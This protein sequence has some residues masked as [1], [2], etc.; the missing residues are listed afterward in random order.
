MCINYANIMIGDRNVHKFVW[1]YLGG[2]FIIFFIFALTSRSCI[3][4]IFLY[5]FHLSTWHCLYCFK[6]IYFS[7]CE[8]INLFSD[9]FFYSSSIYSIHKTV[10]HTIVM[11]DSF[12]ETFFS[13]NS[14]KLIVWLYD[15]IWQ[16]WCGIW[17]QS[18]LWS[19][20]YIV[21]KKNVI[22]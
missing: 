9:G 5:Y 22:L 12:V 21:Q 19:V 6:N 4:S 3:N 11:F 14:W 10:K 18:T 2:N 8:R 16:W 15:C 1:N 20:E 7:C 13:G 17:W